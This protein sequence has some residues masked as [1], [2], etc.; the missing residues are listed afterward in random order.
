MPA[1]SN[2]LCIREVTDPAWTQH[3]VKGLVSRAID[4]R[5]PI[6]YEMQAYEEPQYDRHV[7]ATSKATT[8]SLV[9]VPVIKMDDMGRPLGPDAPVIGVLGVWNKINILSGRYEPRKTKQE[10]SKKDIRILKNMASKVS[11]VVQIHHRVPPSGIDAPLFHHPEEESLSEDDR[12]PEPPVWASGP[13]DDP[14]PRRR[15]R[16]LTAMISLSSRGGSGDAS[17]FLHGVAKLT[18][19]GT[20]ADGVAIYIVEPTQSSS[21]A[22]C[23][24]APDAAPCTSLICT[25]VSSHKGNPE[26][27][28]ECI[29]VT[30]SIVLQALNTGCDIRLLDVAPDRCEHYAP[31]I[32]RVVPTG[33]LERLIVVPFGSQGGME[34]GMEGGQ[35]R[36]CIVVNNPLP[37]ARAPTGVG[38]DGREG[39]DGSDL[40]QSA[41]GDWLHV[42]GTVLSNGMR[43][44]IERRDAME[45]EV[46]SENQYRVAH[47]VS[48]SLDLSTLGHE[49]ALI[50]VEMCGGRADKAVVYAHDTSLPLLHP[51]ASNSLDVAI[52]EVPV[53]LEDLPP[54]SPAVMGGLARRGSM[55]IP[56]NNSDPCVQQETMLQG[57]GI[58]NESD[59]WKAMSQ[60][61]WKTAANTP[62]NG[63]L[64]YEDSPSLKPRNSKAPQ[65]E[66]GNLSS[67]FG[68]CG[69]VANTR[70]P[71]YTDVAYSDPRYNDTSDHNL[72]YRPTKVMTVPIRHPTHG[73]QAAVLGV[74][75][76]SASKS[77]FGPRDAGQILSL[78][79]RAA[80]AMLNASKHTA[81]ETS[82]EVFRK[83]LL[84]SRE[85]ASSLAP[86]VLRG[87]NEDANLVDNVCRPLEAALGVLGLRQYRIFVESSFGSLVLAG[88][89]GGV[90]ETVEGLSC[91][92]HP[93]PGG[94]DVLPPRG[95]AYRVYV[96]GCEIC[97]EDAIRSPDYD[98]S[99]DIGPIPHAV[100]GSQDTASTDTG[101]RG[102]G[103]PPP[104]RLLTVPLLSSPPDNGM[105]TSPTSS[106]NRQAL[107]GGGGLPGGRGG[108]AAGSK[109]LGALQILGR[110]DRPFS[111]TDRGLL[112]G[113]GIDI[114]VHIATHRILSRSTRLESLYKECLQKACLD[115][116]TG[117]IS[118][119][120]SPLDVLA[121]VAR[122]ACIALQGEAIAL[123]L[124]DD[125][126]Y[127]VDHKGGIRRCP[128]GT[129]GWEIP[130]KV[131]EPDEGK[132]GSS[133]S[134]PKA[135]LMAQ[136]GG[137]RKA[138]AEQTCLRLTPGNEIIIPNQDFM[139]SCPPVSSVFMLPLQTS[140]GTPLGCI[141]IYGPRLAKHHCI[142]G[143]VRLGGDE[144]ERDWD[145]EALLIK[146][147][148]LVRKLI[149]DE[150]LEHMGRALKGSWEEPD[151]P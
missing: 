35:A 30:A 107:P 129:S 87:L 53:A 150:G 28:P 1:S 52:V 125:G 141:A 20:G 18:A 67:K 140:E 74:L 32:D 42:V 70:D 106:P 90:G 92:N 59:L 27:P 137:A 22:G 44:T 72:G 57:G 77:S 34:P 9:Y 136:I 51:I 116:D 109:V 83:F 113:L 133:L 151:S 121:T 134:S 61:V 55:I 145:E 149:D 122:N 135:A 41:D 46:A 23:M 33:Q 4:A 112:S 97:N 69:H 123:F 15:T 48:Q 114:G 19:E 50:A 40:H 88:G 126:P 17:S 14:G 13:P 66:T 143:E 39:L 49:I 115:S 120:S 138:I 86:S 64:V 8:S 10:F 118:H 25:R 47:R 58:T 37:R 108:S 54:G 131:C 85:L 62:D 144:G 82:R 139:S 124:G 147:Q 78:S 2:N 100:I 5:V 105:L 60:G 73:D 148:A 102:Q 16:A 98:P 68:L 79:Q 11:K 84:A 91:L 21:G 31:R 71:Y 146:L 7:D 119:V 45:K 95:I 117:M 26:A 94:S 6:H 142:D 81:L 89:S 104:L 101:G 56:L 3:G 93:T 63:A 12:G 110:E 99:V 80:W 111:M 128:L 96:E 38:G 43:G 127:E 75:Q 24:H 103:K 36:G 130:G 65:I 76:V 132:G 29:A